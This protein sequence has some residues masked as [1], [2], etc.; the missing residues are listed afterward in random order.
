MPKYATKM[1]K[2]GT[3]FVT[4]NNRIKAIENAQKSKSKCIEKK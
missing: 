1:Q 2:Y 3:G 4:T